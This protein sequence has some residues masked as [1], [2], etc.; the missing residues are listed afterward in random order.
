M[1]PRWLKIYDLVMIGLAIGFFFL[2]L[3]SYPEYLWFLMVAGVVIARWA[4]FGVWIFNDLRKRPGTKT[5]PTI[6]DAMRLARYPVYAN[7]YFQEKE[8][9]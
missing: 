4:V 5:L 1:P 8:H 2:F 9:W 6:V 3:R 7:A